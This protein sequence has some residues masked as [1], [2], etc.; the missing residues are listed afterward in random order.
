MILKARSGKTKKIEYPLIPLK[1]MVIFPHM[2]APFFVGREKTIKAIE[3]AMNGDRKVFLACQKTKTED[4]SEEDIYEWG[5][6]ASI[7][8]M[9]KLPDGTIR[10]LVEGQD[11]AVIKK[12]VKKAPYFKVQSAAIPD[13][14]AL[15]GGISALMRALQDSFSKYTIHRTKI[16]QESID[17]I[18]K[19]EFPDKLVDLIA[20]Q[21]AL[22]TEQKIDLI[23]EQDT[24]KRLEKLTVLIESENE[25]AALQDK[26][27]TKVKKRLEKNQKDYYLNEQLREINRQLGKGEDDPTG[28]KE[29]ENKIQSKDLPQEVK[30]KAEKEIKRLTRLGP[31]S[32]EAG[33]LRTYIEWINDLPWTEKTEDNKDIEEAERILDEDHYNMKKPKE[34][35][36]DFLAVRQL[37]EK[38]KGPILCFIGPPGTGKTSLGRSVARALGRTFIRISLGGVKDEAEIRG[39]RKTYVGALPGK[40]IQS[41]KKAGTI[42]PVFMLDEIDKLSSDFRGDP[43]SALLEVL[44]PEQNGTF[45]D[46]YLEVPYDLSNVMF[47]TT[48]NSIHTIPLPLRDRMEVIEIPGYTDLEKLRIA[49][50]FI[51]PKQVAENGLEWADIQFQKNA[52]LSIIRNYTMESGVR[53]LEREIATV[54]RKIARRAIKEGYSR[55]ESPPSQQ[56]ET[57]KSTFTAVVTEKGLKNYLGNERFR[58]NAVSKEARPG[59][60]YG[61]AW[62]EMGGMLLPV[63]V[64]LLEGKGELI[65]T[66]NLGDVMKESARIALSFLRSQYQAFHINA[67]FQRDTDIHIHVPEGAIP[68][69]GPSAGIT[70]TAAMLS[71]IS[72]IT[73][74]PG[75]TMT[76][77]ITLTGRI[78][79]VGGVKEKVLA[80]Y[81]NNITHVIM[82]EKNEKD[83]K[84]LPKEVLSAIT[85]IFSDTIKE[86]LLSMFPEN[87]FTIRHLRTG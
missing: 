11:R 76:G 21:V 42:N 1:D 8:Q 62:T 25:I 10:V 14:K 79:P 66:G 85:F 7:L 30:E 44:D 35:I 24:Q 86:A 72:G 17:S 13:S 64:S 57:G 56:T 31:M 80:A 81:R 61:L 6:V 65:L 48:A 20:A 58:E 3:E 41:M 4:P 51:I 23:K 59:M 29:L 74:L 67:N 38:M 40:I 84:E 9:L 73:V 43:A 46:H 15:D 5:A 18:K 45:M 63:E 78:L 83:T 28:A 19:A 12:Y 47:I 53:N 55:A 52:T 69:D 27:H 26:I 22:K 39:H 87:S 32:P 70:L 60:A 68:K 71:A 16:P 77:E 34:R 33:I 36:L 82:P 37:K 2:I 75:Y 49:E 54:I 50:D